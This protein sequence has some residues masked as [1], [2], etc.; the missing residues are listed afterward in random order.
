MSAEEST[1]SDEPSTISP[2]ATT[3]TPTTS[4]PSEGDDNESGLQPWR[5][6]VIG[7]IAYA[8]RYSRQSQGLKSRFAHTRPS[9]TT[10][11][12]GASAAIALSKK[13]ERGDAE[14]V[15]RFVR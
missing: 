14:N 12:S 3:A 5:L 10:F 11:G 15:H 7:G 4:E 13:A 6:A 1:S 8:V 9:L 2:S